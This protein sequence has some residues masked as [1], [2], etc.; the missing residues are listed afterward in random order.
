MGVIVYSC[1][2]PAHIFHILGPAVL[3]LED[4][5]IQA[6]LPSHSPAQVLLQ[7]SQQSST[8]TVESQASPEG[9]D[10]ALGP[11]E[12]EPQSKWSLGHPDLDQ[13]SCSF[14][15]PGRHTPGPPKAEALTGSAAGSTRGRGVQVFHSGEEEGH[16]GRGIISTLTS[17]AEAEN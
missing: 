5:T 2:S 9:A 16:R 14:L 12:V 8:W 1:L 7:Q 13:S 17:Q 15:S 4:P 10:S 6:A 3:V 11:E